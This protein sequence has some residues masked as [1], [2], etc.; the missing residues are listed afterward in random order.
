MKWQSANNVFCSYLVSRD[1]LH[2]LRFTLRLLKCCLG[3]LQLLQL[4]PDAASGGLQASLQV[5][6]LLLY[7]LVLAHGTLV[8][9]LRGMIV[10]Q[11]VLLYKSVFIAL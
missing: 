5:V 4:L 6:H 7:V 2:L 3:L 10:P 9:V 1:G 11:A 8:F